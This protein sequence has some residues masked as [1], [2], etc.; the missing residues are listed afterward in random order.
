MPQLAFREY[1]VRTSAPF[2]WVTQSVLREIAHA[3]GSGKLKR[4]YGALFGHWVAANREV[5]ITGW[6]SSSSAELEPPADRGSSDPIGTGLRGPDG[7]GL[8]GRPRD[9]AAGHVS[10]AVT[11]TGLVLVL[12]HEGANSW[13]PRLWLDPAPRSPLARLRRP[14]RMRLRTFVP[15]ER[16]E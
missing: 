11:P 4:T 15:P 1:E 7:R 8:K 16:K 12:T 9:L 2:A 13:A 5:V 3:A 6:R 14:L 10:A